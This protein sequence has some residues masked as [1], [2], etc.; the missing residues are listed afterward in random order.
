MN[1]NRPVIVVVFGLLHNVSPGR[2]EFGC[3]SVYFLWNGPLAS[4][5]DG[6]TRELLF[7]FGFQL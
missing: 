6:V 3:V 1:D 5:S 2:S 4:M 7:D